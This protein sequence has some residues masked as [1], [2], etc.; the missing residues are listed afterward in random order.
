MSDYRTES[1]KKARVV[2]FDFPDDRLDFEAMSKFPPRFVHSDIWEE[3]CMSVKGR[4][5][6]K[7]VDNDDVISRH[8]GGFR[9]YDEHRIILERA[10]GRP[11]TFRKLFLAT[12]LT[13]ESKKN[14]WGGLY[15]ESLDGA[16][17]CTARSRKA[18]EAYERSMLEKYGEDVTL[19]S[20][21]DAD[22]WE[23]AQGRREFGTG[24]SDPHFIVNGTPS[25]SSGSASYADYQRSQEQVKNLQAQVDMLQ[26]RVEEAQ[27]QVREEMREEM[28]EE[29]QRQITELLKKFGNPGNPL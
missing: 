5:N 21:G 24:S 19:H 23:R 26:N 14:F 27:Q 20:V 25:S 8:T 6:R 3:L 1:T 9:G 28:K 10:L 18:Y 22:L 29:V 15:D 7:K 17:F 13:K 2:G 4:N 16:E 11:P 12:H